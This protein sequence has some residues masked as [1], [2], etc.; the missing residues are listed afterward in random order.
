MVPLL[1]GGGRL[2]PQLPEQLFEIGLVDDHF[3]GWLPLRAGLNHALV[4]GIEKAHLGYGVFLRTRQRAAV[5]R[6]PAIERGLMDED[7]EGESS[8]AID[9]NDISE[10]AARARAA[11]SAVALEEI[12][13]VHKAVG[14]GIAFNAANGIRASHPGIIGSRAAEVKRKGGNLEARE[15]VPK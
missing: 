14:G 10:L 7:F 4:E 8:L 3:P 15:V 9:R 12:I 13:L 11:L 2:Y 1:E 6:R 5:L